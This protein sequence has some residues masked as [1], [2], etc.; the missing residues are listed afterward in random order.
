MSLADCFWCFVVFKLRPANACDSLYFDALTSVLKP[1]CSAQEVLR[2]QWGIH[3]V[4]RADKLEKFMRERPC[5]IHEWLYAICTFTQQ[6]HFEGCT[7]AQHSRQATRRFPMAVTVSFQT[8]FWSPAM[9][10]WTESVKARII[11]FWME[12]EISE[13]NRTADASGRGTKFARVSLSL[14][15]DEKH[16]E[17]MEAL[18]ELNRLQRVTF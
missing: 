13:P 9:E 6:Q 16:I 11:D 14:A 18:A 12:F 17:T 1:S 3:S 2:L 7:F 4:D 8:N 15:L 5:H 10:D